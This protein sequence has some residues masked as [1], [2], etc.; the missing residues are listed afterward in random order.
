MYLERRLAEVGCWLLLWYLDPVHEISSSLANG[1][2]TSLTLTI[3]GI[4]AEAAHWP[5]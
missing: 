1:D 5:G 2:G 3:R 4:G